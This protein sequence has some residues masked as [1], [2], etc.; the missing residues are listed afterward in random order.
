M[1]Y[2]QRESAAAPVAGQLGPTRYR[3]TIT[4]IRDLEM[5]TMASGGPEPQST[6]REVD[7]VQLTAGPA[8]TAG[9][10]RT[11]ASRID[12]PPAG[13]RGSYRS[14]AAIRAEEI[15]HG[16]RAARAGDTMA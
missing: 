10:L 9:V 5:P 6:T 7:T 8:E 13:V 15:L 14:T 12:P 1:I 4:E 2:Q 16:R 11:F 3:V